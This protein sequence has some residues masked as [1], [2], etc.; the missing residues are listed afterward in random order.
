ME[1]I[2]TISV[3]YC[4]EI[5]EIVVGNTIKLTNMK[6][7]AQ[8]KLESAPL[9]WRLGTLICGRRHCAHRLPR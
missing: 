5:A 7:F 3:S 6:N 1:Y 4:D 2:V 9:P 8:S